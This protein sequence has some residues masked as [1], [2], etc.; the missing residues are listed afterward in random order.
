M[1]KWICQCGTVNEAKFCT[2]CGLPREEAEVR[3]IVN[4][5]PDINS[6]DNK[7]NVNAFTKGGNI[8]AGIQNK[9]HMTMILIAAVLLLAAYFGYGKAIEY[10]YENECSKYVKLT[11]DFKLCFDCG[12]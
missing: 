1:S 2:S 10:R 8:A 4:N 9:R 3:E 6:V 11:S 12:G 7:E 5:E